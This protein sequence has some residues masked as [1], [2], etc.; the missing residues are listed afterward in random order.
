MPDTLAQA[1][2]QALDSPPSTTT[3]CST[4]CEPVHPGLSLFDE[5]VVFLLAIWG[6]GFALGFK[7]RDQ[8]AL[9]RCYNWAQNTRV[10]KGELQWIYSSDAD[11]AYVYLASLDTLRKGLIAQFRAEAILRNEV[12]RLR[13]EWL[14]D[15][16]GDEVEPVVEYDEEHLHALASAKADRFLAEKL[17]HEA[18]MAGEPIDHGCVLN[19]YS[20]HRWGRDS[21][22]DSDA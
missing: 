21:G 12:L 16:E 15:E 3:A 6:E 1:S 2:V 4:T 13:D 5:R 10:T 8:A 19:V 14:V 9:E 18:F 11:I 20:P 22:A 17:V 7:G